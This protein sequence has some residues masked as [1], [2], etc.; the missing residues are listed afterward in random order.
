MVEN[1]CKSY[2]WY[3]INIQNKELQINKTQ[4]YQLQK[5]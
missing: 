3:A 5:W 4:I 2:I 1:I